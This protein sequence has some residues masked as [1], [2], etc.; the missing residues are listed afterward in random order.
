MLQRHRPRGV[1]LGAE[2]RQHAH[3]PVA[4][5]VLEPLDDDRAVVGHHP[6]GLGLLVEVRDE[7]E[8]R[9]LVEAAVAEAGDRVAD[10][11]VRSS[12]VKAPMARPSSSG[13][14]GL[15]AVPERHLP[16]LARRRG[17]DHLLEGDV[18]DA[19][20]RRAEEERL[21]GAALVDHLLVELAHA[22]AVGQR[23]GEQPAVGD[24]AGVGDGE[25]LRARA[26]PHHALDPVPHDA[27]PQLGE[28]LGRVPT[29]QEVEHRGEHLV[30]QLGERRRAPHHV[31]EVV[32]R[33]TRRARTWPRSAGRARRCGLR[34]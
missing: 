14:P 1:H 28:L 32:E 34:G 3:A 26:S 20:R 7:V 22:G 27:R 6:G 9:P 15:V 24:R 29:R 16:R 31:G 8:G 19:P 4:D 13:R 11:P 10:V 5:L 33:S 23:D 18:L 12:R 17:D 30:G 25:P 2:G 21:A